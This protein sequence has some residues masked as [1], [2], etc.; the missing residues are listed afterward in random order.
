MDNSRTLKNVLHGIR[1]FNGRRP[2]GR[3]RLRWEENI[4]R[5][6]SLLLKIRERVRPAEDRNILRGTAEETMQEEK[7]EEEEEEK[8][9][10]DN[11]HLSLFMKAV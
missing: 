3:L 7:E 9:E 10:E 8:E 1:V 11:F 4:G 6:S 5:D 2:M